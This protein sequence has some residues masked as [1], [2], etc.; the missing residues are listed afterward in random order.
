MTS[1][2]VASPILWLK[3]FKD[4]WVEGTQV[5]FSQPTLYSSLPFLKERA[6]HSGGPAVPAGL[7]S[8]ILLLQAVAPTGSQAC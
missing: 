3:D 6:Q 5:P 2:G 7:V 1:E 8:T 4:L